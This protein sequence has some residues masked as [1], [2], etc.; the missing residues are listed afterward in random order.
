MK[1]SNRRD[2]V[3]KGADSNTPE[4]YK[5]EYDFMNYTESNKKMQTKEKSAELIGI[6]YNC[7]SYE[8]KSLL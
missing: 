7:N 1:I 5:K 2:A 4:F 8:G 3:N 6:A